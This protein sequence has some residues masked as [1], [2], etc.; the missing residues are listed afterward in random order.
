[1]L[2]S[3]GAFGLKSMPAPVSTTMCNRCGTEGVVLRIHEDM[4]TLLVVDE[5]ILDEFVWYDTTELKWKLSDLHFVVV[6][7]VTE[8]IEAIRS[9]F[10]SVHC[11]TGY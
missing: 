11:R 3:V 10:F 2:E 7:T 6:Y 4:D 5:V 8:H 9:L 1:M